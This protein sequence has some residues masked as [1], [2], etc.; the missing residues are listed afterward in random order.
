MSTKKAFVIGNN[1]KKSLSPTIFNY[2]F[3]KH[4]INAEYGYIE[5]KEDLFEKEIKKITK[6]KDFVGLNITIPYKE[7]IIFHLNK[8][9]T[10][11]KKI[12]A[13]NC[14]HNN[15]EKL[16]GYN[17]DWLGVVNSLNWLNALQPVKKRD[18]AIV[19][20]YG[21]SAKATIHALKKLCFKKIR[22]FNRTYKKI[23]NIK[24]KQIEPHPI[25]DLQKYLK[26]SSL[27]VNT[28]PQ[29]VLDIK[30]P[31]G[32]KH[33]QHNTRGY[34]YDL[35]YNFNTGFLDFF[36]PDFQIHGIHML[37]FQAAPC[38]KMWFGFDPKVDDEL[39]NHV[40]RKSKITK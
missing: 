14:V 17:T 39:I 22:V 32:K 30:T 35:V 18:S 13:V 7:K 16:I 28:I 21:G 23:K 3:K 27:A 24:T 25:K 38:F 11:S 34:G 6:D 40:L 8:I 29:K 15:R 9:D 26:D 20:G 31:S 36:K 5:I 19:V 1:T 33:Y 37:V 12:N 10:N 2:W 4:N